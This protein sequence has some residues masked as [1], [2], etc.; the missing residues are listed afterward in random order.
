ML[1]IRNSQQRNLIAGL[2]KDN[3]DHPTADEIYELAR[4]KEPT[5][6]R[7]TVY[8]NLNRLTEMGTIS[9]L[10]MPV[11]PDHFDCRDQDHYHFLCRKCHKVFDT[12]L[13]YDGSLN[14]VPKSMEGFRIECHRLLLVGLCPQCAG[15]ENNN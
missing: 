2:M 13:E 9:K 1:K 10:T 11:G 15:K 14:A 3:Y 12:P 8:R 6:S 5:I 7:G 4:E